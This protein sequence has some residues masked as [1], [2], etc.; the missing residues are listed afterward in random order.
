M[1][2][3]GTLVD[4]ILSLV[5]GLPLTTPICV[6]VGRGYKCAPIKAELKLM[7]P[8]TRAGWWDAHQDENSILVLVLSETTRVENG[9]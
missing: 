4:L 6:A 1:T 7:T 9:K 3:V 2:T 8:D 5:L